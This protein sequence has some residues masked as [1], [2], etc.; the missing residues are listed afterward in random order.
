LL[1]PDCRHRMWVT[2]IRKQA[3]PAA[4][5]LVRQVSTAQGRAFLKKNQDG[6]DV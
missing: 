2:P 3:V 1:F 5:T 6:L 4:R